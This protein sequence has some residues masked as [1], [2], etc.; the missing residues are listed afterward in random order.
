[1]IIDSAKLNKKTPITADVC[2]MGGGVAGI[3][4]ANELSKSGLSVVLLEA[5]G[6]KADSSVQDGARAV[7]V[8]PTYPDPHESRLRM[9]GGTSNHWAN[10]TSPLSP[11]DFEKRS[12][13]PNSGWPITYKDIEPYYPEAAVY[14][15]TGDDGYDLKYW[16]EKTGKKSTLPVDNDTSLRLAVAKAAVPP[17]QFFR[18]HGAA[19][20][21][22]DN[23]TIVTHAQVTDVDFDS[24]SKRI[25]KVFFANPSGD[26]FEV[27]AT[28]VVMA[29]G[30]LENARMLLHFNSKNGNKLGNQYDSVGRYFMDHPTLNG[31]HV[32]TKDPAVFEF[33]KGELASDY[34]RF[35]LNFFELSAERLREKELTNL[36][37]PLVPATRTELSHG[38]SSFHMLRDRLA[39]KAM[40]GSLASHITNLV[41][42]FDVVADTISR[43][44]WNKPLIDNADNFAGF[45]VPLMMEQTPHRDNRILLSSLKD[46]Y[47][48]PRLSVEWKV[49][50]EDQERLWKGLDIFASEIGAL[51]LGRVRSL[52]E[53]ASRIFSDQIGFGHHHMGTTRMSDTPETGVVDAEQCVFGTNNFSVAGCSVFATGAHVPPTLTIAAT[54]I[55]L[56]K[57]IAKRIES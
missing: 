52:K 3:T 45:Q 43:K 53:R 41:M 2:V 16:L 8:S 26:V 37:L 19:L 4:L 39:G 28:E 23:V 40:S 24:V 33:F 12:G 25:N 9:L 11:I 18:A 54:S 30:G 6:E 5:G 36:R 10:N 32:Y 38:I 21:A 13:L 20:V 46:R 42:D 35:A 7:S 15:G 22:S 34:R 50:Q 1:V 56:A 29:F 31:A 49:H 48:I 55:R 57:I 51:G 44:A 47:G 14:C 27:E 17:T